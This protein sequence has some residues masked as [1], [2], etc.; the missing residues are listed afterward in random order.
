M[1]NVARAP[2]RASTSSTAGVPSGWG[3]SSNVIATP[4]A[5]GSSRAIASASAAGGQTGAI[6]WRTTRL[7]MAADAPQG[8]AHA[9]ALG[10]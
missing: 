1:K 4:D 7:M 2:A 10:I 8:L 5:P 6:R 3:P 9:P